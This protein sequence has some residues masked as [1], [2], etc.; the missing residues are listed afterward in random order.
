VKGKQ[1][2]MPPAAVATPIPIELLKRRDPILFSDE[3]VLYESEL[4]KDR[5]SCG[6]M[7]LT[8]SR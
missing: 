8:L 1:F 3:V 6:N 5:S 2:E 4:G 7:R